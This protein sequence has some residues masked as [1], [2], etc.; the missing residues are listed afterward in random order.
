MLAVERIAVLPPMG[1]IVIYVRFRRAL[2]R[3]IKKE[4]AVQLQRL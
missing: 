1:R 3:F 4:N 2:T